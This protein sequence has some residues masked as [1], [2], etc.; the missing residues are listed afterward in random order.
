LEEEQEEGGKVKRKEGD[1]R[2]NAEEGIEDDNAMTLSIAK[3][4][5]AFS[6]GNN[7]ACSNRRSG[8]DKCSGS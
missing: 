1:R 4:A 5:N 3:E 2:R 6:A 8:E 7:R